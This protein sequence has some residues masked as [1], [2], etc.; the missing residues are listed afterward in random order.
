MRRTERLIVTLLLAVAVAG[1][2][3]IPRLLSWACTLPRSPPRAGSEA[4]GFSGAGR[5]RG[6]S[7]KRLTRTDRHPLPKW[8]RRPLSRRSRR[9]SGSRRRARFR[10]PSHRS[11]APATA[12]AAAAATATATASAASAAAASGFGARGDS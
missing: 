4:R 5:S 11:I 7:A 12:T 1:G 9:S 6:R 8:L 3:S 10:R 2:A